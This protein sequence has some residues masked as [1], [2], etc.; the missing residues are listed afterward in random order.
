MPLS[1][2]SMTP[3]STTFYA[4]ASLYCI[5][6]C[7]PTNLWPSTVLLFMLQYQWITMLLL[8]SQSMT[9]YGTPYYAFTS[10]YF[11][12]FCCPTNLWPPT[13]RLL[14]L[15]YQWIAM[16][17][18]PRQ[19]KTPYGTPFYAIASL[20]CNILGCPPNLW[21]ST[22]LLLWYCLVVLQFI[23]YPIN[24]WPSTVFLFFAIASLYGILSKLVWTCLVL[25]HFYDQ[26][27]ALYGIW[28]SP[29]RLKVTTN[30][31]PPTKIW[32]FMVLSPNQNRGKSTHLWPTKVIGLAQK[33][34]SGPMYETPPI[35][36]PL[37]YLAQI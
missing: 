31:W 36:D 19:S 27:M 17:L 20:Y 7:C 28:P 32:P 11:N 30:P 24:L 29:K 34:K 2:Q 13:V 16:P 5:A 33:G 26:S 35:Y 18:L 6:F 21:P 8:P 4:I 37:W 23:F 12:Y 3:Y 1:H 22:I 15:L 25:F 9:T 10:L 14:M